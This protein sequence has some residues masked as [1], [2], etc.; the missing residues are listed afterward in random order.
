[1][2]KRNATALALV[3]ALMLMLASG[4]ALFKR[5]QQVSNDVNTFTGVVTSVSDSEMLMECDTDQFNEV[6]VSLANCPEITPA[7]GERYEVVHTGEVLEIY[8]PQV[9]AVSVTL[10]E[11]ASTTTTTE[12]TDANTLSFTG[13]VL[14]VDGDSVLMECYDKDKFDRVWVYMGEYI[15]QS[16]WL[17]REYT[18]DYEDMVMPSLPPRI[19]MVGLVRT[20]M[21]RFITEKGAIALASEYWQIQPGDRDP[22]TGFVLSVHAMETPT[23]D[24]PKYKMALRWLVETEDGSANFSTLDV[25]YIDALTGEIALP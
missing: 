5:V 6:W 22:D 15:E 1:M 18:I 12:L 4:C 9:T 11:E 19:T 8:P 25:I 20:G 24:N 10:L 21:D 16:N 14:K 3:L 17:G 2:K 7:V 23:D 13:M